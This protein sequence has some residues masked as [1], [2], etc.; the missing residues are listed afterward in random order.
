MM[1]GANSIFDFGRVMKMGRQRRNFEA[2]LNVN[3]CI[4]AGE[5]A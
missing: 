3:S 2:G 5:M 4:W 1:Q